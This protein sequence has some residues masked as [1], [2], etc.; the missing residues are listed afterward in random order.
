MGLLF[1]KLQ[2]CYLYKKLLYKIFLFYPLRQ[3]QLIYCFVEDKGEP[4]DIGYNQI[5]AWTSFIILFSFVKIV[6]KKSIDRQ[7]QC[8]SKTGNIIIWSN[9]CKDTS[10]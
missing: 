3:L 4:N 5:I 7:D 2:G 6:C 8:I 1:S 10:F 9:I